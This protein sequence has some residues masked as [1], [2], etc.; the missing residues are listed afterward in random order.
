MFPRSTASVPLAAKVLLQVAVALVQAKYKHL[1]PR[2]EQLPVVAPPTPA[3]FYLALLR[4][5]TTAGEAT[6]LV[7]FLPQLLEQGPAAR[8]LTSLREAGELLLASRSTSELCCAQGVFLTLAAIAQSH[9]TGRLTTEA[10][11]VLR[12]FVSAALNRIMA[13]QWEDPP[14]TQTR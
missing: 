11:D 14:E 13:W 8:L 1:D 6:L 12:H 4:C 7:P 3:P 9:H 5:R 2:G 10:H